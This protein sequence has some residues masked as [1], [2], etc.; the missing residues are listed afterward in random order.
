VIRDL[1][2][3]SNSVIVTHY[4]FQGVSVV[5]GVVVSE[6]LGVRVGVSVISSEGV[7]IGVRVNVSER[8]G[9]CV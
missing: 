9:L 8:I 1:R 7:I 4:R 6:L 3:G 5:G 2:R